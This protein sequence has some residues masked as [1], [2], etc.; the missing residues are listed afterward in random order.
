MK[1]IYYLGGHGSLD[2]CPVD[3][4]PKNCILVV[5]GKP[6]QETYGESGDRL[7][8]YFTDA[9]FKKLL[10]T[11]W[12]PAH[13]RK[14]ALLFQHI[15][16]DTDDDDDDPDIEIYTPGDTM[17]NL[18]LYPG[19]RN[20]VSGVHLFPIGDPF[21]YRNSN[22]D[23]PLTIPRVNA[24]FGNS[25]YPTSDQVLEFMKNYG[26]PI[27]LSEISHVHK[28]SVSDLMKMIGPGIYYFH[29]CRASETPLSS[30]AAETAA[31]KKR[32]RM[33]RQ[34]KR[35]LLALRDESIP[36]AP[37]LD[38][39]RYIKEVEHAINCQLQE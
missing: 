36:R 15:D 39:R 25:L 2:P 31:R 11:P 32:V 13:R 29:A 4:V 3:H 7:L 1:T 38:K 16:D 27:T 10:S 28:I 20:R 30:T 24:Q 14:L 8:T 6:G 33:T 5:F 19:I 12:I 26:E 18:Y 37:R 23:V 22:E 34:M 17:P 21:P 9:K 35:S